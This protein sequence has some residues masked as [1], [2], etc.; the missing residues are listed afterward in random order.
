MKKLFFSLLIL[1]FFS[2]NLPSISV[3]GEGW[4]GGTDTKSCCEKLG[5]KRCSCA[6]VPGNCHCGP[7]S[8]SAGGNASPVLLPIRL[9]LLDSGRTTSDRQTTVSIPTGSSTVRN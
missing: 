8:L 1:M 3:A 9:I 4:C 7:T 6:C 5:E 2:F